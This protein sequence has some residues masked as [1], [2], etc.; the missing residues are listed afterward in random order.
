MCSGRQ[1]RSPAFGS[2][3]PATQSRLVGLALNSQ[4]CFVRARSAFSAGLFTLA[5]FAFSLSRGCTDALA[6]TYWTAG[7]VNPVDTVVHPGDYF[8]LYGGG[9]VPDVLTITVGIQVGSPF[10]AEMMI[11]TQNAVSHWNWLTSTTGNITTGETNDVPADKY[12]YESVVLH[13]LGH[14]LGLGHANLGSESGLSESDK[15]YTNSTTGANAS[16]DLD[17]GADGVIGSADDIRGDDEIVNWFDK[18][19]NNPFSQPMSGPTY[20][21]ATYSQ[22]LSDLPAGDSYSANGD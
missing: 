1:H 20:D 7:G 18:A 8:N 19:S 16:Y 12:D 10:L 15:N 14:A 13:E 6:F 2:A 4:I 11:P 3:M 17:A 9:I 21:S 22:D 5:L